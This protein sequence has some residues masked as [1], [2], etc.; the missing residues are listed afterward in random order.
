MSLQKKLNTW[1]EQQFITAEQCEKIAAFERQRAARTFGRSA[2][3]IAGLLIGL[4]LCLIVASNW[5]A[6]GPVIKLAGDF[7]LLGGL[8]YTTFWCITHERKGLTELF[9]IL[10]FLMIGATIGLIGQTFHLD[11][12]WHSFATAWALLGLPFVVV[13]RALFFNVGWL[14]LFFSLFNNG[15]WEKIFDFLFDSF[16]TGTVSAVL[17]LCLLSYAGKKL[18][19]T[20]HPYTLLPKA[21]EKLAMWLAYLSIFGI[22]LRWGTSGWNHHL[23]TTLLANLV[24]FAFLAGRM[25]LA[26]QMQNMISFRR[27]AILTEIYIFILFASHL[28]NLFMS[29]VGFIFGGL[30]VLALIYVFKRTSLYIKNM[31]AFK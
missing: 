22:G 10:S 7:T 31:E 17:C 1:K 14:C 12:G 4:G 23:G 16:N 24:V 25:F 3:I 15:W 2:F 28:S 19:E 27:N 21:F 5:H 9:T 29:G 26:V 8:F 11:G 20:A 18:D 6:L 13:S 30:A